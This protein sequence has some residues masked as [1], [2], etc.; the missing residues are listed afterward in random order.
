MVESY[1]IGVWCWQVSSRCS[2][3]T[4][5]HLNRRAFFPMKVLLKSNITCPKCGHVKSELMPIDTPLQHYECES[6]GEVLIAQ[7][8]MC[9]V[10][11]AYG[12]APC[13]QA[14]VKGVSR[15]TDKLH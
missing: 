10:F 14:Q 2:T 9:C 1:A 13:P 5:V 11:C 15:C 3:L 6:C 12:D 7:E 4:D 8:G